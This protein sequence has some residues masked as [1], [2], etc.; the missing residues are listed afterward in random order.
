LHPLSEAVH[1]HDAL[2]WRPSRSMTISSMDAVDPV[3]CGISYSLTSF[4]HVPYPSGRAFGTAVYGQTTRIV[5]INDEPEN[6]LFV[7]RG[8][9]RVGQWMVDVPRLRAPRS[10]PSGD[11]GSV[12]EGVALQLVTVQPSALTRTTADQ[13]G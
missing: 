2:V 9:S 6:R 11:R 3:S 7:A 8:V 4:H 5:R 1:D 13:D 12:V 10:P